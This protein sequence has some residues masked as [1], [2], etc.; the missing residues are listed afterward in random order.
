MQPYGA[1]VE[2]H[3]TE[4]GGVPVFWAEGP[5]RFTGFLVFRV[6]RGDETLSRSGVSHL[7]EHLALPTEQ[8][9]SLEFNGS[10]DAITTSFWGTGPRERVV[11][12][13]GELC[14]SL[15]D[16]PLPRLEV[17]R[18]ILLT[19]ASGADG[20]AVR[21]ALALR[22]GARGPGL[23][24][25]DELGLHRLSSGDVSHWVK[26]RFTRGNAAAFLT[27]EPPPDMRWNLPE[28]PRMPPGEPLPIAYLELPAAFPGGATG[29]VVLTLV[30]KRSVALRM[31]TW[32]VHRRARRRLRYELGVTY[33]IS[34]SYEPLTRELSHVTIWADSLPANAAEVARGL[35]GV[36]DELATTGPTE[37]ELDRERHD[38]R[39]WR[40]D[41]ESVPSF[42]FF[43][44]VQELLDDDFQTVAE[45]AAELE[46]VTPGEVAQALADAFES[47]LLVLPEETPSPDDRFK[48]YP[49]SSPQ[50]VSGRKL[51]FR[52]L[53]VR[54]DDRRTR[55]VVG[56]DGVSLLR[57]DGTALTV[58]FD[59]CV[60]VERWT[61]GIRALWG[62]DGVRLFVVPDAWRHGDLVARAIE[63]RVPAELVV[64]MEPELDERTAEVAAVAETRVKRGW[65]TSGELDLIPTLLE[66]GEH[67]VTLARAGRGWREGMLVL[68]DRR[69]LFL[70][71]DELVA[72]YQ[73]DAITAVEAKAPTWYEGGK[74]S[75]ST[76]SGDVNFKDIKKERLEE[77]V[78]ELRRRTEPDSAG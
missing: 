1:G 64:P 73:L 24:G 33:D 56:D 53:N 37:E 35:V 59:D 60:A 26:E 36:V 11:D 75:F 39:E 50:R 18:Q 30:A 2:I 27:G 32:I 19:E 42:L 23:A 20:G 70:Y 25:V 45:S 16:L 69:L 78:A 43:D 58:R 65:L 41:P 54:R 34:W 40:E 66:R 21:G 62:A 74:L 31:A 15:S 68:S 61:G 57:P 67:V 71:V 49:S 47:A 77:L 55:L 7:V 8:P 6:G 72:E 17:E 4:I 44:A 46:A 3:R 9:R 29:V 13:L 63:E 14:A 10:V 52:G 48:P 22:Y 51:S 38:A 28:G 12:F 5:G 76:P